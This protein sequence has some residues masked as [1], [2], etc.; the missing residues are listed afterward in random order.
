MKYKT[1][2]ARGLLIGS[3]PIESAHRTVIQK[4]LKQ[5]GQRWTHQGAQYVANLRVANMNDNWNQV[6]DLINK[7]TA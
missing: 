7:A 4:R 1:Y 5:S 2:K 3:G 6:I